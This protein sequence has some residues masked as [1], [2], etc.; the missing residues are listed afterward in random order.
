MLLEIVKI[1]II[2]RGNL[3]TDFQIL[4]CFFEKINF[5]ANKY[6]IHSNNLNPDLNFKFQQNILSILEN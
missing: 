5:M 3:T 4:C 6:D 1:K 2:C